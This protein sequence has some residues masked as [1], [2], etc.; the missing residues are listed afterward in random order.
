[1]IQSSY[2]HHSGSGS[3]NGRRKVASLHAQDV[4]A[5]LS[6][7]SK[8]DRNNQLRGHTR[9]EK[10]DINSQQSPDAK[11]VDYGGK[12]PYEIMDR[13]RK[14]HMKRNQR[15]MMQTKYESYWYDSSFALDEYVQDYSYPD[16]DNIFNPYTDAKELYFPKINKKDKFDESE[17][18]PIRIRLDADFLLGGEHDNESTQKNEF[19][20]YHV[21]PPAMQFWTKALKVYPAKR[22]FMAECKQAS[23]KDR[24]AGRKETDLLLYLTKNLSCSGTDNNGYDI[25]AGKLKSLWQYKLHLSYISFHHKITNHKLLP[26]YFCRSYYL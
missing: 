25:K 5:I 10:D 17:L 22:I 3:G 21:L 19:I 4:K 16:D 9:D 18:R 1:M 6:S 26:L 20:I 24:F 15:N 11:P 23:S 13:R 7:E 8:N 14:R 2:R 12:H